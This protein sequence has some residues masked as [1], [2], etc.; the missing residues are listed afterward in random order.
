MNSRIAIIDGL[1]TPISKADGRFKD[2]TADTLSSLVTKEL[3]IRNDIDKNLYDEVIIGNASNPV[4]AQNIARVIAIR[5]GFSQNISAYTVHRNC[6]AGMQAISSGMDGIMLGRGDIYMVGGVESMSHIP[7]LFKD[8]LKN[9]LMALS[10]ARSIK[11]KLM[12]ISKLRLSM[13]SPIIGV[14]SGLKDP[15]SNMLMG[16]TVEGLAREFNITREESDAYA[17]K[18]HNKAQKSTENKIFQNEILPVAY[19]GDVAFDDD[20]IINDLKMEGLRKSRLVFDK[21]NGVITAKNASQLSDSACSLILMNED[22][23]KEMG[24][25]PIGYIVDYEYVGL[26]PERMGLGPTYAT[27]KLLNKLQLNLKDIDLIEMNEAFSTQILANKIAFN[28]KKFA[29]KYFE[30]GEIIGEIDDDILNINGGAVALGHPIGMSGS[31]IVLHAVK[32]LRRLGK[33]RALAT[34]CIGGGQ[35]GAMILESE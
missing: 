26:E 32:E 1:R 34:L 4:D 33:Q 13:L 6:A 2:I 22:K 15:L 18:S 16:N 17:M 31:R 10:R 27:K 21:E 5:S 20:G 28:S 14:L 3:L 29:K 8:K 11:D 30:D 23:A 7:F 24:L 25:K 35:G 19:N 9:I 12:I